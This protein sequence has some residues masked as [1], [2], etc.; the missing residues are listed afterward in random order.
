MA[1]AANI[2]IIGVGGT[3]T[4]IVRNML[5]GWKE[6]GGKPKHIAAVVI[7]AHDG[8]PEGGVRSDWFHGGS[9][10]INYAKA[11]SDHLLQ[12]RSKLG[13]WWPSRIH[14]ISGVSFHNGCGAMRANGRFFSF[15]FADRIRDA[16]LRAMDS[17]SHA[18]ALGDRAP[19][20]PMNWEA[21]ICM[22]LGNGTGAGNLLPVSAIVRHLL[23][24]RGATTPIVTGVV[25]PA[26]VTKAGNSGMLS[27]HVAAAGVGSLI[28]LQ[29]ECSRKSTSAR[30]KPN[31]PYEH[32][33]VVAGNYEAFRPWHGS[34]PNSP[35]A[36]TAKPYDQIL[37]LDQFNTSGVRHDYEGILSAA[38][39]ALRALLGGSDPTCRIMDLGTRTEGKPFGSIGVMAYAAPT[40]ALAAWCAARQ[41]LH[42]LAEARR[43]SFLLDRAGDLE[44]LDDRSG[45][46]TLG[47]PALQ[48]CGSSEEAVA[49]SVDFFVDHVLDVREE[50]DSN[51]VFNRFTEAVTALEGTFEAAAR[52]AAECKDMKERTGKLSGLLGSI[53]RA[54]TECTKF[55]RQLELEFAREPA[56]K[57]TRYGDDHEGAGTRWLVE[58]RALLF[59]E[60]G[61]FGLASTWLSALAAS[62]DRQ[63][64][65][66]M[67]NEMQ[68][69]L[70]GVANLHQKQDGAKLR[71]GLDG[72]ERETNAFFAF[73]RKDSIEALGEEFV[74]QARRAF[75]F[76]IWQ[77]KSAAVDLNFQ[78]IAAHVAV[79]EGACATAT[80]AL[81]SVSVQDSLDRS[82]KSAEQG[83]AASKEGD[84]L[85]FLGVDEGVRSSLVTS[86]AGDGGA[87]SASTILAGLQGAGLDLLAACLSEGD[88]KA[89]KLLDTRRAGR[90]WTGTGQ[91]D[92]MGQAV[93]ARIFEDLKDPVR[94]AVLAAGGVE[95]L[96]LREG[97]NLLESYYKNVIQRGRRGLDRAAEDVQRTLQESM[98]GR[99]FAMI[100]AEL[101][102]PDTGRT[103]DQTLLRDAGD[104]SGRK[105]GV[106]MLYLQGRLEGLIGAARPLWR[107]QISDPNLILRISLFT[108]SADSALIYQA[109]QA[110]KASTE[111]AIHIQ[112]VDDYPPDRLDCVS[113]ELGG[114]ADWLVA[115][116][117]VETYRKAIAGLP[118]KAPDDGQYRAFETFNPHSE[119]QYQEVGR[120]WLE[121]RDSRSRGV[122]STT[123]GAEVLLALAR[124]NVPGRVLLGFVEQ[125]AQNFYAARDFAQL[126]VDR[127]PVLPAS[128]LCSA[129]T[130]LG[131][132][133]VVDFV[134]W[135]EGKE[136]KGHDA[137]TGAELARALRE[138]IWADLATWMAGDTDSNTAPV[139]LDAIA[140]ALNAEAGK[141]NSK[142]GSDAATGA[143]RIM[144]ASLVQLA[145]DLQ[146]SRGARPAC[147]TG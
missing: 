77:A 48:K 78:R 26:S 69:H 83:I 137:Q 79:L 98:P 5:Q 125:R 115:D 33:G 127:R 70:Q 45:S 56:G 14:P 94:T 40:R 87:T 41:S 89:V 50:G 66:V 139:S 72:L 92:A 117:D 31:T 37:I 6:N 113:V 91:R 16:V 36:L 88:Y 35:E 144:S 143:Q 21:Y 133:G 97:R 8:P 96:L 121:E 114:E 102:A 128:A 131:P 93:A 71:E 55:E 132:S 23:L 145:N 119:L 82:L 129:G 120:R 63:R 74:S 9:S 28:E 140:A 105:E 147:L 13:A 30:H 84:K 106:L 59:I 61:Q 108:F 123:G 142:R 118:D 76:M 73:L 29:Y 85:K 101:E 65:S 146:T 124:M 4:R 126:Y 103:L 107:P 57:P 109:V 81:G 99:I 86:M 136:R 17:L 20:S 51:D 11:H 62:I 1:S 43:T 24:E 42:T 95:S 10:R 111:A 2:L 112:P 104:G 27:Q 80:Q 67:D 75:R 134:D 39:E 54:E 15:H 53:K 32:I 135:L 49:L 68:E 46:R 34:P 22:S 141:L 60:R 110:I 64:Q 47:R 90:G 19:A 3:G 44:V 58:A 130:Q 52:S 12:P 122:S 18:R 7:D 138:L 25:V 38:A 100:D 116:S